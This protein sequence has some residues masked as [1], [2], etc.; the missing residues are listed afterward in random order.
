VLRPFHLQGPVVSTNTVPAADST[1]PGG[2]T[3][4][5]TNERPA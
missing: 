4:S 2:P 5:A 1:E 3:R